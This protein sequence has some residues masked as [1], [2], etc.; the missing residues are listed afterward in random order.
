MLKK[1]FLSSAL[2][3][4][5]FTAFPYAVFGESD[6]VVIERLASLTRAIDSL[7]RNAANLL[8]VGTIISFSGPE[9]HIPSDW[10]LCNGQTLQVNSYPRLYAVISLY[11]G[12][13]EPGTFM[14]PDLR[15]VF[16]RGV[17][18]KSGKDPDVASRSKETGSTIGS[19]NDV[20]SYQDDA[21]QAHA[22]MFNGGSNCNNDGWKAAVGINNGHLLQSNDLS[23]KTSSSETRSKNAYVNFIIYAGPQK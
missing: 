21:F 12:S 15:G 23:G 9:S 14:L 17:S 8:P 4:F 16:L 13:K 3:S 1:A 2:V 5:F 20:G 10:L 19:P 6:P 11:W 18:G 7:Q 22:H